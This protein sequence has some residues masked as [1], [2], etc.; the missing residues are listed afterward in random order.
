MTDEE[1]LMCIVENNTSCIMGTCSRS[2]SR[3]PRSHNV[4]MHTCDYCYSMPEFHN[5]PTIEEIFAYIRATYNKHTYGP[6]TL[7]RRYQK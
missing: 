7:G 6:G 1:F 3:H 5:L 2:L 4:L